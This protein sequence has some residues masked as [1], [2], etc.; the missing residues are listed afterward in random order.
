MT[1][2]AIST[3]LDYKRDE[4]KF[5]FVPSPVM[6]VDF[7]ISVRAKFASEQNLRQSKIC[8]RAKF[9]LEQCGSVL[10]GD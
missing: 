6:E 3:G 7:W 2:T 5:V 10:L 9:A 8:V 4:T 1:I